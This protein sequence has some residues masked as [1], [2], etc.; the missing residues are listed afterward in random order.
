MFLYNWP[1]EGLP[2][3][4]AAM[5]LGVIALITVITLIIINKTDIQ[6]SQG[7][8]KVEAKYKQQVQLLSDKY[9]PLSSARRPI[10]DLLSQNIIPDTEQCLVNF[11]SL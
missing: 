1:F 2:F 8:P 7:D 3:A 6:D 10:T 11:F 5:Y 4:N 9:N